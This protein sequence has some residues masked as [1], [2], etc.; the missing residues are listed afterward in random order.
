MPTLRTNAP[1]QLPVH[2]L[3]EIIDPVTD[4]HQK[5]HLAA[6][7]YAEQGIHIVPFLK[8]GYPKGLSQRHATCNIDL[9]DKWWHPGVGDY[10]GA[11][12]AMAHGGQ[13]GFVAVDLDVK[14]VNGVETLADLAY[15]Y[16]A[17]DDTDADELDTLMAHTPSG[18]RHLVFQF[19]P[20]I[21]SNSQATFGGIDTRGGSKRDPSVNGGITFIEPSAKPDGSGYYRWDENTTSIRPMPKWLV[22]V[23]N[24]RTPQTGSVKLQDAYI[25]SQPGAHGDGRDRN[26]YIDLLRFVGIGYTEEQ[27]RAL[28]PEILSRMSPPDEDMVDA[29]IE[30]VLQS[31]AFEKAQKQE[32]FKEEVASINLVRD[33]KERLV[34]CIEN[35]RLILSSAIFEHEYGVIEY[36]DFTQNFVKN[37]EPLA[38]VV[39]WSVGIQSW[40]S[41]KFKLDFP[42]S[43]IRDHMEDIA[44]ERPH[45]NIAREY[46]LECGA[47]VSRHGRTEDYWGS[48]RLGGG[49]AF[50]KLCYEVLDLGNDNLHPNYTKETRNAYIGFLWFWL[51]GV[52][53]RACVPACKMEIVLNIFGDQGIG[54][55][56]FFRELCPNPKWFTDS[57]QDSIVGGGQNNRDELLKLHA[58]IIVE[59]PELNPIKRGGKSA[60]DKLKQFIS[61]QVDNFRRAY[62]HDAID[63]P[64]TCALAG[65]SNNRDVYRDSTGARRFVS[66]DHGS[67][68]IRVGDKSNGVID[69]IR[70]QLWG[71]VVSSFN[72]GELSPPVAG[73]L[74]VVVPERLREFQTKIN[75]LHRFEEIGVN[76]ILDWLQDKTRVT[77]NEIIAYSKGVAGLRDAKESLVM[78]QVRKELSNNRAWEFKRR[79]TRYNADG[80]HEKV[81]CWVNSEAPAEKDRTVG[82]AVPA[83]WSVLGMSSEQY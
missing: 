43:V 44:Y 45:A 1:N 2:L 66:I 35:L 19:H 42:K 74:M 76:E 9:V 11:S 36:D 54:K 67:R 59:M 46:M 16:G 32:A 3:H 65:T 82:S 79:I 78:S 15:T 37:K 69:D 73:K 51:Q 30:S 71:E 8:K 17:Y 23:L 5:L 26:I 70:D 80:Q 21:L 56:L 27:I 40:I 64:R 41:S 48:G 14:G 7:W 31:E 83:H 25:E 10:K 57:L 63:H 72:E 6:L 60:D 38:S 29:K 28:K 61:A 33:S 58:K 13:A 22:D 52:A 81:N 12:I 68:P 24:G 75:D 47:R 39:D 20:E 53:A 55:S 49:E 34:N 62:G 4:Y 50:Q 77:W 18:G